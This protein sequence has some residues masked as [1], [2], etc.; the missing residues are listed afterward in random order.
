MPVASPRDP[1]MST[2]VKDLLWLSCWSFHLPLLYPGRNDPSWVNDSDFLLQPPKHSGC[3]LSSPQRGIGAEEKVMK[4]PLVHFSSLLWG[5][6]V[7]AVFPLQRAGGRKE[8]T[9]TQVSSS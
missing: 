4:Q 5:E 9:G 3:L 6:N 2:W 7:I 1:D 8:Q